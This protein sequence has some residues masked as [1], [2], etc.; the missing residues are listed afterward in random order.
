MASFEW[1]QACGMRPITSPFL[2][3]VM[4][5]RTATPVLSQ[6]DLHGYASSGQQQGA[7]LHHSYRRGGVSTS[8]SGG[9]MPTTVTERREEMLDLGFGSVYMR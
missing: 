7:T 8:A 9:L 5:Q 3:T 4:R 2:E 6:R 1:L